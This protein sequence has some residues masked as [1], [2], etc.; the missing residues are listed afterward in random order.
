V[1][2][3][4]LPPSQIL[5]NISVHGT[6][7]FEVV[8][9][10]EYLYD[11]RIVFLVACG[12]ALGL[13]LGIGALLPKKYT[14]KASILIEAE[15]NDL[16]ALTVLSPAYLESL[17]SWES[18]AGSDSL[19]ARAAQRLQVRG[20][21]ARVIRITRPANSTVVEINATLND[22]QK[23]Q[24]LAQNIAE[25]AVELSRTMGVKTAADVASE[26]KKQLQEAQQRLTRATQALVAFTA[27]NPS[28]APE[29]EIRSGFDFGLRLA[30]DLSAARLSLAEYDAQQSSGGESAAKQIAALGTRVRALEGQQRELALLL[31]KKGARLDASRVRRS[32][33]EEEQSAAR[34]SYEEIRAKI[35]DPLSSPEFHGARLHIIDPGVVPREASSPDLLLDFI[36]ALFASFIGTLAC[37]VVRFGYVR[38]QR[39]RSERL[40]SLR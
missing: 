5:Q 39:E 30:Q 12:V 37:L 16:R 14:A 6:H 7:E 10:V 28:D 21:K 38:L 13:T 25:Q 3:G 20:S 40:Y 2:R 24:A 29:N 34:T 8:E 33:L 15:G 22:P 35:N 27:S 26:L 1:F 18:F 19:Y 9:F 31:E 23:A 11:K 32:A 36:A 4:A 17:K